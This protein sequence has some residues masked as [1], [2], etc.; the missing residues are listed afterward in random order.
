MAQTARYIIFAGH[1]QGVGFRFTARS[2][3]ERLK[4]TGFV[5]NMPD[6]TV[7]MFTQGSPENI[8]NCIRE[9][10]DYF[11]GCIRDTRIEEVPPDPRYT[12]FDITF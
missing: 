1:V 11:S 5:R 12:E 8:S 2:L 10:E 9:I 7:E 4:L 6:G 3:A